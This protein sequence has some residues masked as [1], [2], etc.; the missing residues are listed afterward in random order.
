MLKRN[1]I[2]HS[3]S[4]HPKCYKALC[5]VST[6]FSLDLPEPRNAAVPEAKTQPPPG[7]IKQHPNGRLKNIIHP[8]EMTYVL[9]WGG[10]RGQLAIFKFWPG[11]R[12][13]SESA[14]R[15]ST[16]GNCPR[17]ARG[18]EPRS[19]QRCRPAGRTGAEMNRNADYFYQSSG[20][21]LRSH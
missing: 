18:E 3:A 14:L 20:N 11:Q 16:P 9:R 8:S 2:G 4:S 12:V 19:A 17:A 7:R 15:Q 1:S 21:A 10:R 5:D 6:S 13:K